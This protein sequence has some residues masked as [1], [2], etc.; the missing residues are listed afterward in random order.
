MKARLGRKRP[1]QFV[2]GLYDHFFDFAV[3]THPQALIGFNIGHFGV[4]K[5]CFD[6]LIAR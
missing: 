4:H 3:F 1:L 2:L 6:G 5:I